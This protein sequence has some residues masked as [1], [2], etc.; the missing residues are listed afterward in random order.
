[1]SHIDAL[2][3]NLKEKFYE[4]D[5]YDFAYLETR[6]EMPKTIHISSTYVTP[7]HFG[8]TPAKVAHFSVS[9]ARNSE[10]NE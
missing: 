5:G 10:K 2:P 4:T 9:E 1:M 6:D 8:G 3:S 7:F